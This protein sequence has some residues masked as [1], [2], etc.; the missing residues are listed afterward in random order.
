[1][2]AD[3]L[4]DRSIVYRDVAGGGQVCCLVDY[5]KIPIKNV[6]PTELAKYR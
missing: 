6:Y 1:M 5:E 2:V 4:L 3:G